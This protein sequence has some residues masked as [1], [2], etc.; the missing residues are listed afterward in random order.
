LEQ[1][2]VGVLVLVREHPGGA[3]LVVERV[4]ERCSIGV[5]PSVVGCCRVDELSF[6]DN[7]NGL[8]IAPVGNPWDDGW[9]PGC[10]LPHPMAG[11]RSSPLSP[12]VHASGRFAND[13]GV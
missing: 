10:R 1:A 8:V 9:D 6:L 11:L 12:T 3:W 5:G 4:A 2:V 13:F 7:Q